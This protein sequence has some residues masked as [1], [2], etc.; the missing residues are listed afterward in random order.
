M[1]KKNTDPT[2]KLLAE[3]EAAILEMDQLVVSLDAT[4]DASL[5]ESNQVRMDGIDEKEFMKLIEEELENGIHASVKPYYETIQKQISAID[6]LINFDFESPVQFTQKKSEDLM[7]AL[8]Q[9][10]EKL[11]SRILKSA[12]LKSQKSIEM[13]LAGMA[14]YSKVLQGNIEYLRKYKEKLD[15]EFP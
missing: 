11:Q 2:D 9:G 1:E 5:P 13:L 12:G 10:W 4:E 8:T 6:H 15:G 3:M 14:E 7:Q